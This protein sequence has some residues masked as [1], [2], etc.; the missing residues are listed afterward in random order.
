MNDV[1]FSLVEQAVEV[2]RGV[3]NITPVVSNRT[4]D[5]LSGAK[6]FFK[7]ENFQR[8]GAFKFRG[9]YH[10]VARLMA[11]NPTR[12][13]A[14]I[15]SGNHAQGLALAC[16]LLGVRAHVVMPKPYSFMKH[17]AV[18]DYGAIVHVAEDRIRAE[19]MLDKIVEDAGATIIHPFNDPLVI[20]GQGTIMVELLEQ[21]SDLDIVLAPVGGGGLLS[22]LCV[23]A[24]ACRPQMKIFACEP[25]GALDAV[26]SVRQNCIV[27]MSFPHTIADGLR[28]SLGDRTLPILRQHLTGFFIVQER[29][30][31]EAMRFA[32][33][34]LKLVI[35][36]SS[37]VALAPL[38]REEP[39]LRGK[40]VAVVL[41][42]GNA[43]LSSLWRDLDAFLGL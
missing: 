35:E 21:V 10:A 1:S 31:V 26:E 28:T 25:A 7:C 29:E 14:T 24:Q 30:I 38:L 12:T 23:A 18:I 16:R 13:F 32:Y 41:T 37:A 8:V 17:Q 36:P 39:Q 2:L 3:A 40:R 20:A 9:A 15:S 34:R 43:E 19:V 42:G 4:I 33:E 6:V 5:G 22:G 11:R 27:P